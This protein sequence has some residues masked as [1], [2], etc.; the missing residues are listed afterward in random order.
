MRADGASQLLMVPHSS[1]LSSLGPRPSFLS[2]VPTAECR[3]NSCPNFHSHHQPNTHHPPTQNNPLFALQLPHFSSVSYSKGVRVETT[4]AGVPVSEA[5]CCC[6]T[7]CP[8]P[9]ELDKHLLLTSRVP[10]LW[11]LRTKT[12]GF[13]ILWLA[14]GLPHTLGAYTQF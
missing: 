13:A 9:P 6:V 11:A 14:H 10:L 1:P 2:P 12:L 7:W 8:S 3:T 4:H 5:T